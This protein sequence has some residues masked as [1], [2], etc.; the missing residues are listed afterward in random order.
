M[1]M[2]QV[3]ERKLPQHNSAIDKPFSAKKLYL[4]LSQH[5]G[6]P[7]RLI[8]KPQ[9]KVKEGDLIAQ[10]DGLISASLCSPASGTIKG[11]V[12]FNHPVLR[13]SMA[14]VL[15]ADGLEKAYPIDK[16]A[17]SLSN[18]VILDKI[19]NAG[20]VGMGGA[21]FPA[22]VKLKPPKPIDTLIVNGCECEPYLSCDYRLMVEKGDGV[23]KGVE[24]VSKV[25][26]PKRVL[27]AIEENKPEAIK[28]FNRIISAKKYSLPSPRVVILPSRYPQGGE[29]QLIYV[30]TKRKVP[31]GGLPFDV[32]CL[33]HNVGTLYAIYEAVYC[34][35]PL[36]ERVV[37]FAGGALK[38]PKNILIKLGTT[39]KELFDSGVLEFKTEPAKIVYGGPMMGIALRSLDYPVM[40]GTSGILFLTKDEIDTRKEDVCIRCARCVDSCP[41]ELLP[42]E[43]VKKVKN[44]EYSSLNELYIKDCIECGA[45]SFSCPAKIP[46]VHYIKI[47]KKYAVNS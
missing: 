35:K 1:I 27:F 14:V 5:T 21:A 32:G 45:C 16:T 9:D 23:F 39:I 40:K 36:I 41:M 26:S 19:R 11:V 46:I 38:E 12:S 28:K 7:S 15:E 37:T 3:E 24:L 4:H 31:L 42:L 6:K 43:F 10:S 2:I 22:Y 17:V 47:G 34:N 20:I 13:K 18:D 33:V 25:I 30:L 44:E 8:V 29:K